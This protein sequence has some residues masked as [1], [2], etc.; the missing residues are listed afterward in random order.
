ML[1]PIFF[2]KLHNGL[3]LHVFAD[4]S[5]PIISTALMLDIGSKDELPHQHGWTHLCEHLLFTGT[6]NIPNFDT[7][8]SDFGG[9]SNA[10]TSCDATV[11]LCSGPK[12]LLERI[13]YIESERLQNIA[14][15]LSLKIQMKLRHKTRSNF[16]SLSIF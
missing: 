12:N 15:T 9:S 2:P 14:N 4:R 16:I 1:E 6:K 7:V 13:L 10:W 8:L 11:L 5:F 3:Q